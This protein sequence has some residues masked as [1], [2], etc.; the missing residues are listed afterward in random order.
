[1]TDITIHNK[2]GLTAKLIDNEAVDMY[3]FGSHVLTVTIQEWREINCALEG[4][5]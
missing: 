5:A 4:V 3:L 2:D 1:M